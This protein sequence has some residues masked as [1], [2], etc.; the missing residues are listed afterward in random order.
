M[1]LSV[2]RGYG[3]GSGHDLVKIIVVFPKSCP[4]HCFKKYLYIQG[5]Q[6]LLQLPL[7]LVGKLRHVVNKPDIFRNIWWNLFRA[8]NFVW[9]F[10]RVGN[11]LSL[12]GGIEG[13]LRPSLCSSGSRT[14]AACLQSGFL[15]VVW[16]SILIISLGGKYEC[17][18]MSCFGRMGFFSLFA[19]H[20][21][22]QCWWYFVFIL[23]TAWWKECVLPTS[24]R[25]PV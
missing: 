8:Q 14:T 3:A 22:L 13:A 16:F 21:H 24:I 19:P 15:F 20:T 1:G 10:P 18:E 23:K 25:S 7:S 17:S 4:K 11:Q 9:T 5:L 6:T 2:G 12:G